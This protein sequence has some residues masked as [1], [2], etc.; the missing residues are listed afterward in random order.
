MF[1]SALR[2]SVLAFSVVVFL[3]IAPT[4]AIGATP[5]IVS[6]QGRI[7]VGGADFTGSS[8]QFK[9]ALV[10][11]A[12]TTTY[13]SNDN[14]STS[15]NEPAAAVTLTVNKGLYSVLLGDTQLT[16]M[17]N[18]IP[19]TVFANSDVRLRI[20]FNDGTNGSQQLAPDQR[21]AAVG[22]ALTATQ[23]DS[24][25]SVQGGHGVFNADAT[26]PGVSANSSDQTN[27]AALFNSSSSNGN[28][29][30]IVVNNT[31]A[32]R[33]A[34]FHINNATN[35]QPAILADSNGTGSV[36][37]FSQ[38]NGANTAN[39]IAVIQNGEGFAAYFQ[40]TKST[41][42]SNVLQGDQSGLGQVAQFNINNSQNTNSCLSVSTNGLAP[43]IILQTTNSASASP[44]ITAIQSGTGPI[45]QVNKNGAGIDLA[46]F[47]KNSANVIRFNNN[48]TGYFN[49]GIINSGADVAEAF[50]VIGDRRQY[51][52]GD[53]LILS[54]VDAGKVEKSSAPYSALVSGV[55]ATKPG[56]LLTERNI[57]A[58]NSDLVPMGVVGVIPTKV[59]TENGPIKI[60]DLLVT[61]SIPGHAMK[62]TDR[63]R[64]MGALIGKALENFNGAAPGKIRVLVNVK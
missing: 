35:G 28:V 32:S 50:P 2:K 47:Q 46:I 11:G 25:T 60:G 52:P 33:A 58:D 31:G 49:G 17:T 53:V 38:T 4:R 36:A 9:F 3:A 5:G 19:A 41:N 8:G 30:G 34:D 51:E 1:N 62:G 57:D 37:S 7:Q 40:K 56:V 18:A 29:P 45:L 59:C 21:I 10:S 44:T 43:G 48:G 63:D 54:T 16:N 22:Y 20:W 13:W 42:N 26:G 12:G 14:T 6:Y 23:A 15:G 27:A 64:M 24:A 55:H 61:S 39:A